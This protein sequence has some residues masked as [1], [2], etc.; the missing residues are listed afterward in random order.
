MTPDAPKTSAHRMEE[1]GRHPLVG[2]HLPTKS[3]VKQRS[4][5]P[6]GLFRRHEALQLLEPG[7][8]IGPDHAGFY[9]VTQARSSRIIFAERARSRSLV[10]AGPRSS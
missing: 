3:G 10:T 7:S 6:G 2:K 1:W 8:N 4:L 9:S 5:P